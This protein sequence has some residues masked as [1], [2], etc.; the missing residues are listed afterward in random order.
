MSEAEHNVGKES[1]P[2][3]YAQEII[4]SKTSQDGYPI[5]QK[6]LEDGYFYTSRQNVGFFL[7]E[8]PL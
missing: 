3:K 1:T 5:R 7:I 4:Y 8:K 6:P 2:R